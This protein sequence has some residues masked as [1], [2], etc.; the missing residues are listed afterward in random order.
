[1]SRWFRMYDDVLNDPKA[2]QLSDSA[3]RGWVNLMCLASKNDGMLEQPLENVAFSLR[4]SLPKTRELLKALEAVGL[5]DRTE[6]GWKPH[7]WEARQYKSDVSTDRVKR[8]RKRNETVSETPPDTEQNRTESETEQKE[9][10]SL[11]SA[12][13]PVPVV[14]SRET[15]VPEQMEIPTF[16][17][18][19]K[20]SN[21]IVVMA[22]TSGIVPLDPLER[23]VAAYNAA[24][25]FAQWPICQRLT[26]ARSKALKARLVECGG[27]QVWTDAMARATRSSFLIG[28]TGRGGDHAQWR[29][30]FDFILQSKSFTKLMEGGYDDAP[31]NTN[32]GSQLDRIA[33]AARYA[34]AQGDPDQRTA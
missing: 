23:A 24:A 30:D 4:K 12:P 3:F 33:E 27:I 17:L 1:M 29:P 31:G 32:G 5:L 28:K 14:V 18:R 22:P 19:D 9:D 2:Q 16:L 6:N 21:A 13:V 20:P 8:F 34:A 11:R 15:V 26:P 25:E 7:N 10:T